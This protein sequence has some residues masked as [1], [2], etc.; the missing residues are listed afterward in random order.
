M[1]STLDVIHELDEEA[2]KFAH[3]RL[4]VCFEQ[5][6]LL[7]RAKDPDRLSKLNDAIGRGGTP[8]GMVGAIEDG[9][10][11]YVHKRPLAEWSDQEE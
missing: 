1:R 6:S 3:L 2:K 7:I 10:Q 8:I 11:I 5:Y 9:T 4:V